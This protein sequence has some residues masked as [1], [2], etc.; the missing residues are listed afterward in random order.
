MGLISNFGFLHLV[1][2]VPP[3]KNPYLF[4]KLL[5]EVF[6]NQNQNIYSKPIFKIFCLWK[7]SSMKINFIVVSYKLTLQTMGQYQTPVLLFYPLQNC[8]LQTDITNHGTLPN[9]SL[10]TLQYFQQYLK[11]LDQSNSNTSNYTIILNPDTPL[12]QSKKS[13]ILQTVNNLYINQ[14]PSQYPIELCSTNQ[15]MFHS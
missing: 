10:I 1:W 15:N 2:Q 5:H 7:V 3:L 6:Q 9:P 4:Y 12:A 11:Q 8:F 13:F 14:S